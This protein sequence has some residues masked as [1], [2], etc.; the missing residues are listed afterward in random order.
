MQKFKRIVRKARQGGKRSHNMTCN[1]A[2]A[3]IGQ[4]Y[5]DW[6]T[7][8]RKASRPNALAVTHDDVGRYAVKYPNG[9]IAADCFTDRELAEEYAKY[10]MS[11]GSGG[12]MLTDTFAGRLEDEDSWPEDQWCVAWVDSAGTEGIKD[13]SVRFTELKAVTI[14]FTYPLARE[15]RIG[16]KSE[17]GFTRAEIIEC[18]RL[19]YRK[20]YA[21]DGE[22]GPDLPCWMGAPKNKWGIWGHDIGDLMIESVDVDVDTGVVTLGIGS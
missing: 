9:A 12:G 16:F 14:V 1:F 6:A 7:K 13:P 17:T 11:A 3:E 10:L 5:L 22:R 18:I 20:I 21:E 4:E 2:V 19:G 15:A 8:L